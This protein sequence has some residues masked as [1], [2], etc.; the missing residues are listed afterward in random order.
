MFSFRS[1]FQ[2]RMVITVIAIA[3]LTFMLGCGSAE[4]VGVTESV[5]SGNQDADEAQDSTVS[6]GDDSPQVS[7]SDASD[8]IVI[9]V[10]SK[11]E[12][13]SGHVEQAV[14]I[15]HTEIADR[16]SEVTSDKEAEILLYCKVGGRAGTAKTSLEK[17]GFK[18]VTNGGG[19][20][21]VKEQ[22]AKSAT[23]EPTTP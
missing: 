22:L 10:R 20:D 8:L 12:W 1:A 11:E 4:S 14:H 16:I 2:F 9:D 5:D 19:Y 15:P 17:I 7:G 3:S 18:N 13:D 6:T 21:D 23:G